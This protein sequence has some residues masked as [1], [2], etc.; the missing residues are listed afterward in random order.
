LIGAKRVSAEYGIKYTS[1]RDIVF[2]GELP[3][4]KIGRSWYFERADIDAW[5]KARKERIA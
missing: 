3:V 4:L 1:L 2:R 5:I